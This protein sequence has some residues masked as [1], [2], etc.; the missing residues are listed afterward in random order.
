MRLFVAIDL[1]DEARRAIAVEQTRLA[2]ELGGEERSSLRLVRPEQMHLTLAFLGETDQARGA[3]VVEALDA[4]LSEAPFTIVFAGLGVFPPRGAP[5]VLWL[6]VTSGH[7]EVTSVQRQ[8]ADRLAHA[9]V[10]PERRP[11]HPHLTLARWRT[12]RQA[13]RERALAA[14][15]SHE[16]A[17]VDVGAATLYQSRLSPS[18]SSY[19]ALATA[20]L[21][22]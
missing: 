5:I 16:V 14:D 22:T 17:R 4:P 8:I 20:R 9:G 6:G 13:D 19:T 15:R 10:A 3:A 2:R 11:Y 12:A 18:G 1:D 21:R 7:R